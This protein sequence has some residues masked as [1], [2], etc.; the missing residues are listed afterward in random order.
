MFAY[1]AIYT[2]VMYLHEKKSLK[3]RLPYTQLSDMLKGWQ[4]HLRGC[5]P[6]CL[7]APFFSRCIRLSMLSSFDS[8]KKLRNSYDFNFYQLGMRNTM[9]CRYVQFTT[10][11]TIWQKNAI[12]TLKTTNSAY[13]HT[14]LILILCTT[15]MYRKGPLITLYKDR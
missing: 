15:G 7:W 6:S 4:I 14:K 2:W 1:P 9:Q 12:Q 10:H 3:Q 11:M 13:Q 5:L 8:I